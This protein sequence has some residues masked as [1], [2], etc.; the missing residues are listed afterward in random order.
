MEKMFARLVG[1]GAAAGPPSLL[2]SGHFSDQCCP[3]RTVPSK[4]INLPQRT[5][6]H[7][8]LGSRCWMEN[9]INSETR[10]SGSLLPPHCCI[11]VRK[12]PAVAPWLHFSYGISHNPPDHRPHHH[13]QQHEWRDG[14]ES[15]GGQQ[16][17]RGHP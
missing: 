16:I 13:Q 3:V 14:G 15:P 2:S 10:F 5:L 17:G 8:T 9:Q 1:A 12:Q 4:V 11:S 6:C 7:S